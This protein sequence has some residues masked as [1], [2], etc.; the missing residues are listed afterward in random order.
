[1]MQTLMQTFILDEY[2]NISTYLVLI[3]N[4]IIGVFLFDI[5]NIMHLLPDHQ[6]YLF[7]NILFRVDG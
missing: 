7:S 1:M 3:V 5:D 2:D 6:L 4:M